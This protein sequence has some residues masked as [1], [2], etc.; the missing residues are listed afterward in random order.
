MTTNKVPLFL[1][2][3]SL[4]LSACGL[5][6]KPAAQGEI[7][8]GVTAASHPAQAT[9]ALP[10]VPGP[11]ATLTSTITPSLEPASTSTS[12]PT[13]TSTATPTATPVPTITFTATPVPTYLKL[14]G[15]VIVDQAVCHYGPGAPYLYKYGVYKGSNLEIIARAEP[16]DYIEVQAI[17]GNNPCWVNPK[18]MNI[19]GDLKD[20]QPI[21]PADVKLP[22][23]PY[24]KPPTRYSAR[25]DGN[26]V[27]V[28]WS[29]L[30]LRPGDDS[31][32]LPYVVEAWVCKDGQI[33]FTPVGTRQLAVKIEDQPGCSSPSHARLVAAEKHGYTYP[34]EIPW[35]K[36]EP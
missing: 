34:V 9:Q 2:L 1:V 18:Y 3:I 32:Q 14:R 27:T 31:E 8:Q 4:I 23:S 30:V 17:R 7:T 13:T 36:A 11:S 35:P 26:T 21:D 25:R 33:I 15:E 29:Q 19:K 12:L 22:M 28:F 10:T 16:G 6:V 5:P 24:Y 20:V